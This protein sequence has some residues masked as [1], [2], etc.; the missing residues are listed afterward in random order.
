[1]NQILQIF[2]VLKFLPMELF[3]YKYSVALT[4]FLSSIFFALSPNAILKSPSVR[5]NFHL[6]TSAVDGIQLGTIIDLTHHLNTNSKKSHDHHGHD[7][8]EEEHH[9]HESKGFLGTFSHNAEEML[10][11][12][13][14]GL[15]FL[16]LLSVH[17][18]FLGKNPKNNKKTKTKTIPIEGTQ[19]T[20]INIAGE[21]DPVAHDHFTACDQKSH[22]H[23]LGGCCGGSLIKDSTTKFEAVVNLLAISFHSFFDGLALRKNE[24]K[25]S[26]FVGLFLHKIIDSLAVGNSIFRSMFTS[27]TKLM[28][29]ILYAI[30]TPLGII[31]KTLSADTSFK[32]YE[33]YFTA[34]SLG[35]MCFVVFYEGIGHK[36]KS[37][38]NA[39]SK[40]CSLWIGYILGCLILLVGEHH[41]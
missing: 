35:S 10:P 39:N 31:L 18:L 3:F 20:Y 8:H 25:S 15:I 17:I 40:I 36:F 6:F 1:M 41:H 26:I 30:W 4:I 37:K 24:F 11:F 27:H 33:K 5:K 12:I 14:I 23:P 22:N 32:A 13:F 9:H 29:L 38:K 34:I 7:H 2:T 21:D 28:L 16:T 19:E